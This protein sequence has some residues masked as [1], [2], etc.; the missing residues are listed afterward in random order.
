MFEESLYLREYIGGIFV[1]PTH[2]SLDCS[3]MHVLEVCEVS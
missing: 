1:I 2:V 3:S